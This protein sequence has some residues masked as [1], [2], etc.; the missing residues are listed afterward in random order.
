MRRVRDKVCGV[1][2]I[3][4]LA[5]VMAWIGFGVYILF[6][7]QFFLLRKVE[8]DGCSDVVVAEL[9]KDIGKN[10]FKI[11]TGIISDKLLKSDLTLAEAKIKIKLPNILT[12]DLKK[13]IPDFRLTNNVL[14]WNYLLADKQGVILDKVNGGQNNDLPILIWQKVWSFNIGDKIPENITKGAEILDLLQDN[15]DAGGR[16][17]IE[18]NYLAVKIT[19]GPTVI[20]SLDKEAV[21][22]IRALQLTMDQ[23]KID[24]VKPREIDLRFNN[25]IVV[26]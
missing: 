16:G 19:N 20:F 5:A 7:S 9:S 1:K 22:E 12:A 17:S 18:N 10:V 13:R 11:K 24:S 25:P 26:N 15:Y 3:A 21:S 6:F 4:V 2:K 23:A 14:S 8:C